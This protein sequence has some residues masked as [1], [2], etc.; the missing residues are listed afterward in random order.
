ML[1]TYVCSVCTA[2]VSMRRHIQEGLQMSGHVVHQIKPKCQVP[3]RGRLSCDI[4]I[5]VPKQCFL[6]ELQGG[7]SIN[8]Y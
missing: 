4:V 2:A 1:I 5:I 7:A 8:C 6:V 3:Y